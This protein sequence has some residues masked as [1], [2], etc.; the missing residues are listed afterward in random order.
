MRAIQHLTII[1]AAI[2]TT[3][4]ATP[5]ASAEALSRLSSRFLTR[6][7][8]ALLEVCISG[9][10]PSST[11]QIPNI[12]GVQITATNRGAQTR[13][14]P[15]RKLEYVFEFMVTSYEIGNF[16]IPSI[17]VNA[18]GIRSKTEPLEFSVFNPDELKWSEAIIG[19]RSVR[20]ASAFKVMNDQPYDGETIPIEIK[21]FVPRD[22]FVEDWGIPDFIRDGLTCWRFQPSQ[23]RGYVNLLGV[24]CVSVAYPSTLTATR[25]GC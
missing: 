14:L 4:A 23:M 17:E 24:P 18:G 6:G 19:G 25:S 16:T 1:T 2:I 5:I 13:L 15:G 22:L 21:L 20:Y 7:E 3:L 9:A 12:P 11:P 8:Q 10:T